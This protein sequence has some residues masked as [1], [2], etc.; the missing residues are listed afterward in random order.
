MQNN[1]ETIEEQEDTALQMNQM[2]LNRTEE[3]SPNYNESVSRAN[4][5]SSSSSSSSSGSG[6]GMSG[7]GGGY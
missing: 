6:G 7:G 1:E 4:P 5:S 2:S 3:A